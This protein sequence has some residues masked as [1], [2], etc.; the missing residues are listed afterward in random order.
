MPRLFL[1]LIA[2]LTIL[3][4]R[5]EQGP[6]LSTEYE[7]SNYNPFASDQLFTDLGDLT[8]ALRA[9]MEGDGLAIQ[10]EDVLAILQRPHFFLGQ[11]SG[12]WSLMRDSDQESLQHYL[13]ES[14]RVSYQYSQAASAGQAGYLYSENSEKA[15]LVDEMGLEYATYLEIWIAAASFY[16]Q[17]IEVQLGASFAHLDN[18]HAAAGEALT[19]KEQ[20]WDQCFSLFGVPI[21]F[22]DDLSSLRYWGDWCNDRQ[23]ELQANVPI[24][25]AFIQG[26]KAISDQDQELQS[27]SI[28]SLAYHWDRII[29]A[30]LAFQ[31]YKAEQHY[32][33]IGKRCRKLS[34]ARGFLS[35]LK[36]Y[37]GSALSTEVQ[38][39]IEQLLNNHYNVSRSE[40]ANILAVLQEL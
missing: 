17:V 16:R 27:Q 13:S 38:S 29:I 10:V 20:T 23:E 24:M 37:P 30:N 2:C 3:S 28:E 12:L 1:L 14:S 33:D 6:A 39:S 7:T 25:A 31:I 15:Y 9:P 22:P 35:A 34:K 36:Y 11:G 32:G 40:L 19:L 8:S 5:K 26:R 21:E 18:D 4:C